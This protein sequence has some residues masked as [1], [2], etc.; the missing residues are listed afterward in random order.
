MILLY[1]GCWRSSEHL[2]GS[3]ERALY[4]RNAAQVDLGV[5]AVDEAQNV[6]ACGV[7]GAN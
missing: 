1:L 7:A 5:G 4:Y 6:A 2:H 3:C